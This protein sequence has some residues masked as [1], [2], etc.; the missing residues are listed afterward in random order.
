MEDT[1]NMIFKIAIIFINKLPCN[2]IIVFSSSFSSFDNSFLKTIPSS[3]SFFLKC[4]LDIFFDIFFEMFCAMYIRFLARVFYVQKV[5]LKKY[6]L[7]IINFI[8]F[9]IWYIISN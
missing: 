7:Q 5:E 8:W 6:L 4:S 2:F 9:T 3:F 1:S